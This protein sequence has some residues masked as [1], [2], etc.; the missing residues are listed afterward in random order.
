VRPIS[1][2]HPNQLFLLLIK[3]NSSYLDI[4][5]LCGFSTISFPLLSFFWI[6]FISSIFILQMANT[7][8]HAANANTENNRQNNNNDANPPP[9]LPPTLEQVLAMQAHLL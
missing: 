8:N 7:R 4:S 3:F 1:Q 2:L 6:F 5:Y 9:S